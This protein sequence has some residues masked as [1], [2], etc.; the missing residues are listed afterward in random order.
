[1]PYLWLPTIDGTL[2]FHGR[3]GG[4]P[5]VNVKANPGDYLSDVEMALM[6]AF[7]ARKGKWLVM[8]DVT[9]M[10]M[11][12]NSSSVRSISFNPGVPPNPVS[13]T[14]N[15][16][17][18]TDLYATIWTVAGGYNLVQGPKAS[19]DLIGGARYLKLKATTDW[20]LS[21][22]VTDPMGSGKVFPRSGSVTESGDIWDGI[23]GV[24]G[25]LGLGDGKWFVPYYLDAGTGGSQFTWQALAGARYL[26]LKATTN[27]NLTA[28]ITDPGGSGKVFP[29]SGGVTEKG[30]IWDG[31]VGV[32]GR[33]GLGDGKWFVPYYLDG[34]T[35][36]VAVHVA[37]ADRDR[38]RVPLGRPRARLPVPGLGAGQQQQDHPGPQALRIRPGRRVPLL[39]ST[40]N[41]KRFQ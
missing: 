36:R 34:G 24:K 18:S 25:R 33:L 16:G 28:T 37:G 32:K 4:N 39:S 35:G 38:L 17:T 13:T 21:A 29:A 20:Q 14:L 3:A 1:M 40:E 41:Y 23:V 8:S 31:I 10:K 2:Q 9:Y 22:D 12:D 5:E 6:L 11:S 7:E 27:W 19:L 15:S 30:D 26:H